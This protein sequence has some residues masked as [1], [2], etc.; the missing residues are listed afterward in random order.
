MFSERIADALPFHAYWL[1]VAIWL[2]GFLLYLYGAHWRHSF[3]AARIGTL[4]CWAGFVG[5]A[6]PVASELSV[7]SIEWPSTIDFQNPAPEH[8]LAAIWIAWL[9]GFGAL[10]A[11]WLRIL[12]A[13]IGWAGFTVAMAATV[14]SWAE[15]RQLQGV[16]AAIGLGLII[17]LLISKAKGARR[18]TRPGDY[19]AELL[20]LCYGDAGVYSR[21]IK[22]ELKCN[23][24]LSRQAAA[25]SAVARLRRDRR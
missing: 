3:M 19:Q 7:P 11:G 24:S 8:I 6:Y 25:M 9:V 17:L 18:S 12:P 14:A 4:I 1:A 23:P 5:A 2:S 21:L 15:D 10:I 16:I 22:Y 13:H 20:R